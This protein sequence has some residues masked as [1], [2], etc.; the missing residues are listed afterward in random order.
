M[1]EFFKANAIFTLLLTGSDQTQVKDLL[2]K[3]FQKLGLSQNYHS[4]TDPS[5]PFVTYSFILTSAKC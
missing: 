1:N 5:L 2:T 3:L 4:S